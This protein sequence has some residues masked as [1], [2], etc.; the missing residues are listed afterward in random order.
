MFHISNLCFYGCYDSMFKGTS[1][2]GL[3][4]ITPKWLVLGYQ[5]R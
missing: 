3:V 1:I 4:R 2:C 5:G